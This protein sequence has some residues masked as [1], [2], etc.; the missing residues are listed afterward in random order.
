[1]NIVSRFLPFLGLLAVLASTPAMAQT[2]GVQ[3]PELQV[4]GPITVV[5]H[6]D[7]IPTN[8]AQGLLAL[9]QY[10]LQ[11]R[12]SPD[13]KSFTLITWAP[14]NNHFQL[15]EVYDSLAA[16]NSHVEAASTVMFRATIQPLIGSPYDE[17]RYVTFASAGQ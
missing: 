3:T 11:S 6:V 12:S 8:L 16:F 4:P 15:I 7:F 14:T 1:M 17:R 9:Q 5:A 13:V 10:A 2:S